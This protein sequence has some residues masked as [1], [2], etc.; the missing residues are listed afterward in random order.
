LLVGP[1]DMASG[2]RPQALYVTIVTGNP[3]TADGLQAYLQRA[4]V[5]SHTTR[6]LGDSSMIPPGSTAVVLFPDDFES[7]D[8]VK[9]IPLLRAARPR[10][11]IVVV[12]NEPHRLNAVLK[13]DAESVLPV[14]FSKP[15]FGWSI[16]DAIRGPVSSVTTH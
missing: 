6:A 8:V 10:L 11:L 3:E 12:T 15:A 2:S 4:G 1:L 5:T 7:A 14:V 16:L 13:A 9:R